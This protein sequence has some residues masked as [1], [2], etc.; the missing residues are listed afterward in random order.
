MIVQTPLLSL[1][2]SSPSTSLETL[3]FASS[4]LVTHGATVGHVGTRLHVES[5][6]G[7][8]VNA[9]DRPRSLATMAVGSNSLLMSTLLHCSE[10]DVDVSDMA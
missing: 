10:K 1:D 4:Y 8:A 9:K 7:R 2:M 3:S 6:E 5:S